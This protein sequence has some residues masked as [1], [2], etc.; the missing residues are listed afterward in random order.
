VGG[1]TLAAA[2]HDVSVVG[3][4]AYV[5]DPADPRQVGGWDCG[6]MS[7]GITVVGDRAYLTQWEGELRILDVSDPTEPLEV[8]RYETAYG[9][10]SVAAQDPH[11][12]LADGRGGLDI[13]AHTL[14]SIEDSAPSAPATPGIVLGPALPNPFNPRTTIPIELDRAA[15]ARLGIYDS[16]GRRIKVLVDRS[17]A[18]GRHRFQWDGRS[19]QGMPV[20]SGVYLVRLRVGN[21]ETT[22]R[23]ALLK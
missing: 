4:F 8:A 6:Y 18:A 21:E 13:F 1:C 14:T 16:G 11:V 23:V 9:G 10:L 20:A 22:R 5:A 3:S 12:Y 17:L 15:H 7:R 19:S 2:A